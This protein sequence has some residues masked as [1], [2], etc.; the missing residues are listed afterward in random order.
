M[1]LFGNKNQQEYTNPL[2]KYA[3]EIYPYL[4]ENEVIEQIFPL[5]ISFFSIT[6]KRFIFVERDINFKE[7]KT[8]IYTIPFSKV[9]EVALVYNQSGRIL[10]K[11]EIHLT[12]KGKTH[13]IE[14]LKNI[15]IRTIY[16]EIN[17]KI[18]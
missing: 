1:G 16:N 13:E 11:N 8:L 5:V 14:F 15:D 2:E 9:S 12:T 6:N 10:E 7:P 17:K 3:Q 18:L 4:V